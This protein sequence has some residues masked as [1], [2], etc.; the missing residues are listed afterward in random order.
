MITVDVPDG[1]VATI[2]GP[3]QFILK[4][5]TPEQIAMGDIPVLPDPPSTVAE[6]IAERAKK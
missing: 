4:T 6:T 1:K 2:K 3:G 5:Q